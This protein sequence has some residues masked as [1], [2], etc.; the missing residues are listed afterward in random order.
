MN[1]GIKLLAFATVIT[2]IISCTQKVKS[3]SDAEDTV[4]SGSVAIA[5]DESFKPILDEEAYVFKAIYTAADPRINYMTENR[6][7]RQLLND[8]VRVGILSRGLDS[9]EVHI[10][11]KRT[12]T[13]QVVPFAVDAVALI[14]NKNSN[15]T[16]ITVSQLKKMLNGDTKGTKNIVFDN[17]NGSLVR[18]LK[19]F[20]GNINFNGKNIYA[21]KSNK[22]VLNYVNLHTDAIGI[23]GFSWLNDPDEDY[24][25]AVDNVQ[26][27]G[28]KDEGSKDFGKEYY[29]PSQ[30]TLD[31]NQYPL[32]RKLYV[33]NC[34]G[35]LGLGRGF[36]DFLSGERGQRIILKS[37]LLP[38]TIPQ[39]NINVKEN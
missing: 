7:L 20:A 28:V 29:K 26:I 37:G 3:K 23:I 39:R 19:T 35:K 17:P 5:A 14:V 1:K 6:V 2:V 31:L 11:K 15:D 18:Y 21:L 4:N 13:A 34:T 12:L 8:S 25:Q 16:T 38:V 24:K 10:I 33:I 22:E 30:S 27:V 36:Q 32:S 9:N